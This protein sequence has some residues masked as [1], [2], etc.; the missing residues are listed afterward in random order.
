MAKI[1]VII[2]SPDIKSD[3]FIGNIPEWQAW[4]DNRNSNKNFAY[5][6]DNKFRINFTDDASDIRIEENAII[7]VNTMKIENLNKN[8][9]PLA[10]KLNSEDHQVFIATHNIL[11]Q[12]FDCLKHKVKVIRDYS[13]VK[14]NKK[15]FS[16]IIREET[17]LNPN[18]D[19]DT[20]FTV[21]FQKRV[22]S[23]N[24]LKHR[25]IN[26]FAPTALSLE[27][28]AEIYDY[29]EISKDNPIA[30]LQQTI[31]VTQ[32]KQKLKEL[33]ELLNNIEELLLV[34]CQ[35]EWQPVWDKIILLC[36]FEKQTSG[37]YRLD[38]ESKLAKFMEILEHPDTPTLEDV[39][40][41][42]NYDGWD[43]LACII[44]H[45][46]GNFSDWFRLLNDLLEKLKQYTRDEQS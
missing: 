35:K 44:N 29:P 6:I 21:F 46:I 41:I 38:N 31:K 33:G 27:R 1:Q 5:K 18:A 9:E 11:K 4:F 42:L 19:F 36:G 39:K 20:I 10:Q 24:V 2:T 45:P 23:F 40:K 7:W 22:N 12:K 8:L 28:L 13:L 17:K 32:F 15:I 30:F 34:E 25:L 43:E 3:R 14:E 16:K 26:L 37:G